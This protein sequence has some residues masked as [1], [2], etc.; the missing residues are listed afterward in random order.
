MQKTA[1]VIGGGAAGL[2]AALFAARGG[3]RAALVERTEKLG[4]KIYIT[5]KGRCNLT[6]AVSRE[7]FLER[8]LHNPRFLYAS[9]AALDPAGLMRLMEELGVPLKTERG[10][11]V[12]PASDKASDVTSALAKELQRLGVSVRL[13]ARA[14]EILAENGRAAGVRLEDGTRLLAGAVILATGG[15]SYPSTGSTGDGY[16][17]AAAHGHSLVEPLPAL[18][19]IETAENWPKELT[20]LTLKNVRLSAAAAEGKKP[21]FSEQ[22][23]LLFTHFGI[24]GPLALTLSSLLPKELSGVKL[25]IDLKPA[26]DAETLEKRLIRDLHENAK[27]PLIAVMSGLAPHSLALKLVELAGLSPAHPSNAVTQGERR[28]IVGLL[29]ALPLTPSALRGFSEAVVT[30]GGIPVKEVNP[31]TME[32]KLLPGLFIAGELLDVDATT[33]GFNLQIAFSTG[34]LAGKSAAK[35]GIA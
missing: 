29:K 1:I 28:R 20:G 9:L 11:R 15:K 17:L 26:L 21:L 25:L 22:G 23:E 24:S 31:S 30:R 3:A 35:E 19:P 4:K 2:M 34:A 18:V 27:R 7:E 14:A 8:V 16:Q 13:N 5:G 33:G 12:F 32:S 10:G 6:N